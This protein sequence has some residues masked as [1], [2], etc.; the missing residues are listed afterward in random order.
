M[1]TPLT[2]E[3]HVH[4][5]RRGKGSHKEVH[6][7]PTPQGPVL[8]PGR[9]PRIA[10]LMALAIRFGQ[11]IRDG[12]IGNYSELARLGHVS[13]ARISQIMNLLHLAPDIQETILFLPRTERGRAPI[14]L[15][16]LQPIVAAPE[17]R[18]QRRMWAALTNRCPTPGLPG[19]DF[20]PPERPG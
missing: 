4:F 19:G 16:Q 13:H 8:P 14:H 9:V 7:G 18:K 6:A 11:L 12:V 2:I 10:R 20:P 3:C 1:T 15:R 5:H 17:W